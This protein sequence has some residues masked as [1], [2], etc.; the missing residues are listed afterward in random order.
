MAKPKEMLTRKQLEGFLKRSN[1]GSS[2]PFGGGSALPGQPMQ[3]QG[4]Q[5]P[6]PMSPGQPP[7]AQP[8]MPGGMT[9]QP[10]QMGMPQAMESPDM[11]PSGVLPEEVI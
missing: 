1:G 8:P 4:M 6:M 3:G 9:M 5:P 2:V 7:M 11:F 10:P